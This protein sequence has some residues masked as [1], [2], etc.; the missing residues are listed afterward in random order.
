MCCELGTCGVWPRDACIR[1]RSCRVQTGAAASDAAIDAPQQ[2]VL[3]ECRQQRDGSDKR[4]A[5]APVGQ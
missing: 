3:H 5:A 2:Q 1:Q 4:R